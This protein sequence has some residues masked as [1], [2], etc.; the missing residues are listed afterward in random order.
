MDGMF[1]IALAADLSEEA[2]ALADEADRRFGHEDYV[3]AL[4]KY[5]A[6][7]RAAGGRNVEFLHR[8][9]RCHLKL[10]QFD[11]AANVLKHALKLDPA[12]A[13]LKKDYK[14]AVD[15]S[16]KPTAKSKARSKVR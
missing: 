14:L 7:Q 11:E 9:G 2:K 5:G 8:I 3:G 16:G 10:E 1:K 13:A 15:R 4:D 6:A 12:N